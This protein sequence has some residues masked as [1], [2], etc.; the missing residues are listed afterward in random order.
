VAQRT[1]EIGLRVALG[2]ARA[3]VVRPMLVHVGVLSAVG[4]TLGLLGAL[5]VTPVVGSLLIG[6]APND[7]AGFATVSVLLAAVALTATWL[8]AWHASAVDPMIALREN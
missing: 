5:A 1:R 6:V 3:Q 2:A 4:L 7:P 8:P